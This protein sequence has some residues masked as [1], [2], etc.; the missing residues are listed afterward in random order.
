MIGR[1]RRWRQLPE[2]ER[3][4][5]LG[6]RLD[7][8]LRRPALLRVLVPSPDRS[9]AYR[10]ALT[11]EPE[12]VAERLAVPD[13]RR[14]PWLDDLAARATTVVT[15]HPGYEAEVVR[16]ARS[17]LVPRLE[18]TVSHPVDLR[19]PGGGIA[20]HR[21]PGS[22]RSWDPRVHG[23][24]IATLRADGADIR[25]LWEV[26]RFRHLLAAELYVLLADAADR[27]RRQQHVPLEAGRGDDHFFQYL[28]FFCWCVLFLSVKRICPE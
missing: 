28:F 23:A 20:W 17:G 1:V 22:G 16:A 13:R 26:G 9:G 12:A 18:T 6:R 11:V 14:G 4:A 3:R 2:A 25:V 8:W 24:S 10:G 15:R 7:L 27:G 21:D 19:A 5:R